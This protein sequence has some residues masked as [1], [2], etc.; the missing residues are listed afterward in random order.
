MRPV[1]DPPV[2]CWERKSPRPARLAVRLRR[3]ARQGRPIPDAM[4]AL[5][6]ALR[7]MTKAQIEQAVSLARAAA[8]LPDLS[9]GGRR[10]GD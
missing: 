2:E 9:S 5:E 10:I 3:M 1:L 4:E 8:E 6:P 7:G